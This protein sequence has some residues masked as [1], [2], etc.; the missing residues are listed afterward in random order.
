MTSQTGQS[1]PGS[2]PKRGSAKN[3]TSKSSVS[4][5]TPTSYE[6][7]IATNGSPTTAPISDDNEVKGPVLT[8][9]SD[10]SDLAGDSR[11][12]KNAFGTEVT[13]STSSVSDQSSGIINNGVPRPNENYQVANQLLS[14]HKT[15][16]DELMESL[17]T[18]MNTVREFEALLVQSMKSTTPDGL[19]GPSEDEVLKYFETV[20][21]FLEKGTANGTKLREAMERI[22]QSEFQ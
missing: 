20:Y 13:Q 4:Q 11:N 21:G 22:S 7:P 8:N 9:S 17:R 1:R 10:V 6:E 12:P 16:I 18:E 5:K 14:S 19:F 3:E 2:A 15:Y